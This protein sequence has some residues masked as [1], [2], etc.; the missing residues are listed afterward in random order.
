V[1]DA[2]R[3]SP[4]VRAAVGAL[5]IGGIF[6]WLWLEFGPRPVGDADEEPPLP[7]ITDSRAVLRV[8]HPNLGRTASATITCDGPSHAATGFWAHDPREACDALASTGGALVA[9]PGC[10]TTDGDELRL[11][12]HGA[13]E[14]RRFTHRQQR[15]GCPDPDDW[16]AVNA[17]VKPVTVPERKATE[18]GR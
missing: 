2:V 5:V 15:G 16:L 1:R 10:R 13:F 7:A 6:V 17:L 9:G 3:T 4:W 11:D 14:G 8:E 12:V 18:P